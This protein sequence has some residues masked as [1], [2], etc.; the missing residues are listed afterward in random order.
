[1][2]Y[3][4]VMG[5]AGLKAPVRLMLKVTLLFCPD[6]RLTLLEAKGCS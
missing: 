3:N 4:L 5:E 2:K 1:M 6:T